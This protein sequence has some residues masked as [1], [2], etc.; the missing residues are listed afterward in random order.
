[1]C[2]HET[3][4]AKGLCSKCYQAEYG[5]NRIKQRK[6]N[7]LCIDCGK[8]LDRKGVRCIVCCKFRKAAQDARRERTACPSL[9]FL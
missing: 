8:G 6:M 1:M 5:K 9:Y 7:G 3:K 4:Y 2:D